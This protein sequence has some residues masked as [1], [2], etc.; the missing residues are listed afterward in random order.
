MSVSER[1][2]DNGK[3]SAQAGP[4]RVAEIGR[5]VVEETPL[6][7]YAKGIDLRFV[8]TNRMHSS[9]L[10]REPGE[11]I[12]KSDTE[13]FG[14]AAAELEAVSRA[15]IEG[16]EPNASE[17]TL[18]VG[19]EQRTYLE[20]IFP[21]HSAA[22]E[23]IGLG[24]IATDITARRAL[25]RALEQ[26]A[27]ELQQTIT[28]LRATQ[29][30]LVLQQKMAALGAL[31]AGVAH[32][33]NTPLGIALTTCTLLEEQLDGLRD[34]VERGTL[35]RA[36][37]RATLAQSSE[38]ARLAVT[39]I[40]RAA[41]LV[42]S[43]KQVAVD[44]SAPSVRRVRFGDWLFEV[45]E[46]L[47]PL[48]RQHGA[49]LIVRVLNNPSV[50]LAASELQQIVTNLIVNAFVHAFPPPTLQ[51][52]V[53]RGE[54][55]RPATVEV[56]V[57]L[58]ATHLLLTVTDNGQG[59]DADIAARVLEPFFTTRRGQGGTGL[60]MH[61]VYT[62]VTER[63]FGGLGLETQPGAGARWRVELPLGTESLRLDAGE[64]TEKQP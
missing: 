12:G 29:A 9:L 30:Q 31:V 24:G 18:P 39:N 45:E 20:T 7:I 51:G 4:I 1:A 26:R 35:T 14:E 22:G 46:S 2:E 33:V 62:L 41:S 55:G 27:A 63:F 43:F 58:S 40:R 57:D 42:Q 17:Y 8:L 34:K 56:E 19:G 50:I 15:V 6:V 13:L 64:G 23:V 3:G 44:Q 25:E 10:E 38:A 21:L 32:E 36:A 11:V 5:A 16:G 49:Q 48:A 61:I 28:E 37:L 54:D 52:E 60:G 53:W 47:R 59:M